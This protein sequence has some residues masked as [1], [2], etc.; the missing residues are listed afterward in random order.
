MQLRVGLTHT[1]AFAAGL[2]MAV[3]VTANAVPRSRSITRYRALDAFA[4]SIAYV[5]NYYV[6]PIDDRILIYGAI[7]GMIGQLDDHSAFLPPRKY[8]RV[9][10]DTEGAFAG[11]GLT[12]GEGE[13]ETDPPRVE[14]VVRGSPADR[15]GVLVDDEI[16][17]IDGQPTFG[18][19][20]TRRGRSWHSRL[21]G[22]SGTRVALEIRRG[23]QETRK[24]VLVRERVKVPTVDWAM[25]E[26]GFGYIEISKFQEATSA[27]VTHALGQIRSRSGGQI[28]ALLLDLR[29]NP[30]GLLDQGVRVADM[31]LD[32]GLI[33]SIRGR[34]GTREERK[35]ARKA[36]TWKVGRLAI[37]VDQATASAAEI[38]A[39]ALQ[40]HGR[41][42]IL[43][44]ET[45]GKGSVQTFFDLDDGSGIK[46]TTSR[47]FT[48]AGRSLEGTGITPDIPIEAFEAEDIVAGAP[49]EPIEPPEEVASNAARSKI[50]A[51]SRRKASIEERLRDDYQLSVAHQT[52]RQWLGSTQ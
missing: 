41:A 35:S 6:E 38:V 36:G 46:I 20:V 52:V 11:V 21:R 42:K 48:P 47:Y 30:G 33:V 15:A 37:L 19:G 40:D 12:L 17:A 5:G 18:E 50:G 9:R 13:R 4:Q 28:K 10:Q 32:E 2:A 51:V 49:D 39:A 8:E 44:L 1:A 31:F 3:A 43:G 14:A 16:L 24:L 25:F 26:P 27:D 29:G 22:R 7:E 23:S 45:Y 34:P